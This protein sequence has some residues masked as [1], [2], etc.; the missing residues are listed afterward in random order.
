MTSTSAVPYNNAPRDSIHAEI[1][2]IESKLKAISD[3]IEKT[4]QTLEDARKSRDQ[5]A[6][7]L[8]RLKATVAP[9]TK[10]PYELL[11]RI[12]EMGYEEEEEDPEWSEELPMKERGE[13]DQLDPIVV[14]HVNR[15]FRFVPSSLPVSY[16]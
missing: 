3:M 11:A 16:T 5:L 8:A 10:L 9:V 7:N 2:E 13:E 12:F 4:S 15:L 6:E 1:F 14:S